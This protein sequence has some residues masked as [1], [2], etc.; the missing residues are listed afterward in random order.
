MGPERD[1]RMRDSSIS[2]DA[3]PEDVARGLIRTMTLADLPAGLRLCRASGWNQVARDWEQFLHLNPSGARVIEKGGA[4]V[5]T[6]AT[7]RYGGFGWIAMV[8]VD[9]AERGRG[10]GTRLLD[11]GIELMGDGTCVRLDATPAGERIY[12]P[13][14]FVPEYA[15]SRMTRAADARPLPSGSSA[16]RR[17]TREDLPRVAEW[18]AEAFGADRRAMLEWL[19]AGAP[20]YAWIVAGSDRIAGYML[21]RHGFAFEHFGPI[22]AENPAIAIDLVSACLTNHPGQRYGIDT[23]RH[24]PAWVRWLEEAGFQEQRPFLRMARHP[25]PFGRPERYF[26]SIGP[27]FA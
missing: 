26:A 5:G 24:A 16:A 11:A 1:S 25:A 23:T 14:G 19:H 15:L 21:G 4:V 20:E 8:L 7:L 12:R 6:V 10:L 17:M 9:P 2:G 22:V 27:E 18:D 13:R 3:E